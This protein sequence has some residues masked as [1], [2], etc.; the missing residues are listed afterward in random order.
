MT[1][2]EPDEI[3]ADYYCDCD[4]DY[5]DKNDVSDLWDAYDNYREEE[6]EEEEEKINDEF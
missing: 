3:D 1:E 5:G 4:R 2:P 6:E